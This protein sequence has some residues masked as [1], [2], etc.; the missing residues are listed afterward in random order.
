MEKSLL[1]VARQLR[2][3]IVYHNKKYYDDDAPEISD[4][5][6]DLLMRELENLEADHPELV[7]PDSPTQHVG[8]SVGPS[9]QPVEH[10]VQME[11]LH[12][13]F[14]EDE[15]RDFDKRVREIVSSPEYVV[16]PKI[17]G[18]SVSL[19]Y[20]NGIFFRGS[21]RGDG[22]FGE[23]V[24]ENLR[25]I[26]SIPKKINNAPEFLEIRG[27][28]Y[29]SNKNFLE[30]VKQQEIKDE[31]P[32]KNPRNAA[33]GSLRQKNS[34]ITAQRNLDIFVFNVQQI[35]GKSLTTHS[36]ALN[37]LKEL[38][39]PVSP[40]YRCFK[41]IEDAINEIHRIGESRGSLEFQTDGAVV[42]INS[43]QDRV[44]IGKTSKFPKWAEAFKYPPE[45]RETKL[46]DVE[47]N[48]GRTGVLTPIAV[49][50]PIMLAGTTVGRATLHNQ[51]FINEKKICI[52]D[53]VVV[54][55]AGEIIP[56]VI[57]VKE[58]D[59]NTSVFEMPKVCPSCGSPVIR[60]KD[61]AAIRCE[62]T[63][64]PAQLLRHM[65]HFVSRDA[66]DIDGL[67]PS[68]LERL[69]EEKLIFS[70]ADIYSLNIDAVKN[71]ERMGEKSAQNLSDAI[72]KS[73]DAELSQVLFALGIRHV[74]KAASKLLANHF[75]SIE[76]L[77]D[78]SLEEISAIDGFGDIMAQSVQSYFTL[79]KTRKLIQKLKDYGV[80]MLSKVEK[81]SDVLKDKVFVLTGSLP[82][83]TR[84]EMTK[85]IESFGGKVTNSVS[86]KTSFLL[87]GE[88][89]GSKLT[90]AQALGVPVIT[91]SDFLNM[92]SQ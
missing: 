32:F 20:V 71:M 92:I 45:Q 69:V 56:E 87:A 4:F 18:L 51:D 11:S 72:E 60:E 54:R 33:A 15:I 84:D 36:Q 19:E 64:C 74:G 13:S 67:G 35:K 52:G 43:F 23:D 66:M 31:K 76:N 21:T 1:D 10:V 17:D 30:I 25:T 9:F 88:A 29:M 26:K 34:K 14:S 68:L 46:L 55:K 83:Y 22:F 49:L 77:F 7:T 61:E 42:K 38:G 48:V 5:E 57:F 63:E 39:F 81:T 58:H 90:K 50:Q 73:K 89:G 59:E 86:K 8:G 70:P 3:K 28:V 91:E 62:N 78:A 53:T 6:Y 37:Y 40:S 47:V 24:T 79:D 16:E 44:E 27:E 85:L 75:G 65:I 2:E 80:K 41:N 82:N 12:D